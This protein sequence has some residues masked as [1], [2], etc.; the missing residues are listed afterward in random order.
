MLGI[1]MNPSNH[2]MPLLPNLPIYTLK[3]ATDGHVTIRA[4]CCYISNDVLTN[5]EVHDRA[6]GVIVGRAT[7]NVYPFNGIKMMNIIISKQ[8]VGGQC[9]I[10]DVSS[11]RDDVRCEIRDC[12]SYCCR[13]S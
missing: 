7:G 10:V 8:L 3:V 9:R 11:K 4:C 6:T 5:E 1:V 2:L 13:K 12:D